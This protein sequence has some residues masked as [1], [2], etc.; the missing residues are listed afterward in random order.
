MSGV[1]AAALWP[2]KTG[3]GEN[4]ERAKGATG[5]IPEAGADVSFWWLKLREQHKQVR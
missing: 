2:D 3:P 5:R 1:T 4:A